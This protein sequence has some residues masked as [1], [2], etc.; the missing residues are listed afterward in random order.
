LKAWDESGRR[1]VIVLPTGAGKTTVV[2]LLTRFYEPQSGIITIDGRDIRKI[3]LRSLRSHMGIVPQDS[4]LFS[5][6]IKENIKYG[7]REATDEEMVEAAKVVGAHDFIVALPKGYDTDVGERGARLSIG[8]RQLICFTRALLADPRILVLDEA[9]SSVDAYTE[10]VIQKALKRLLEGRTS[11]IIAHRLSTVRNADLIL[12]IEDG[13]IVETGR[14]EELL[15][16][17]GV[18]RSLYEMQF[19]P[20]EEV[21]LELFAANAQ[22]LSVPDPPSK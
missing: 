9:T 21:E 16:K 10:Q 7:R 6:T 11:F 5:G 2:N 20:L 12:V 19:K 22:A 3:T 8:Q 1:G 13:R 15:A 17:G 4:Y 18:Y 14:H